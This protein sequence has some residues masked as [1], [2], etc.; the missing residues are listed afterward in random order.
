MKEVL[1]LCTGNYYRSRFAECV[2]LIIWRKHWGL[3]WRATSRGLRVK[4]DG[5]VNVG[6][7]S[8]F[9]VA[10]LREREI[11]HEEPLRFPRQVIAEELQAAGMVVAAQ[12]E[13]E[14]RAYAMEAHPVFP[15]MAELVRAIGM[16]MIWMWRCRGEALGEIERLV[17]ELV[18]ELSGT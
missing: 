15:E 13:G 18:A 2:C 3:A 6:P 7:I 14:H 16:C 5:S 11:A 17:G 4:P 1:F 9:T 8:G 12:G 10:G